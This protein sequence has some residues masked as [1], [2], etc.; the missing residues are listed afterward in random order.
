MEVEPEPQ[1]QQTTSSR[2]L[3]P[4]ELVL[5]KAE[6]AAI[7]AE[8]AALDAAAAASAPDFPTAPTDPDPSGATAAAGRNR[9]RRAA[10]LHGGGNTAAVAVPERPVEV[11]RQRLIV[12]ATLQVRLP[13]TIFRDTSVRR[14]P[15]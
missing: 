14:V 12:H 7:L 11:L 6:E 4:E 2:Q 15:F 8:L 3:S 10:A 5:L 13:R 9:A 1:Q